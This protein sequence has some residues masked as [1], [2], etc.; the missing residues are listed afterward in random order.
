MREW[1][2]SCPGF[3]LCFYL[4]AATTDRFKAEILSCLDP[5]S[6][7]GWSLFHKNKTQS[8]QTGTRPRISTQDAGS[9]AMRWHLCSDPLDFFL[10]LPSCEQTLPIIA[11]VTAETA[12][13][14][15]PYFEKDWAILPNTL[16]VMALFSLM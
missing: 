13:M 5:E 8:F 16:N 15:N 2:Y 9:W 12:G 11:L 10:C 1:L 6:E 7:T 14:W 4:C 3:S